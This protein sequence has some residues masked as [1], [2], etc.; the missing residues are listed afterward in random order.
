MA[1]LIHNALHFPSI[2]STVRSALSSYIV[3]I[4][5][6]RYTLKNTLTLSHCH[7]ILK[8]MGAR[9]LP[10]FLLPCIYWPYSFYGLTIFAVLHLPTHLGVHFIYSDPERFRQFVGKIK[11]DGGDDAPEDVMGGFK[12]AFNQLNWRS[13]SCKV[14]IYIP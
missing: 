1:E 5:H 6:L 3:L 12:V 7:F 11:A 13:D 10:P 14:C 9:D 2:S 4:V 8:L